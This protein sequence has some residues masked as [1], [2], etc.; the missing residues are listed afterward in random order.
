MGMRMPKIELNVHAVFPCFQRQTPPDLREGGCTRWLLA[1]RIHFGD[2]NG[3][4]TRLCR[5]PPRRNRVNLG[6]EVNCHCNFEAAPSMTPLP[7]FNRGINVAVPNRR[8]ESIQVH[9]VPRNQPLDT[10]FRILGTNALCCAHLRLG[11]AAFSSQ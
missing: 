1:D 2:G 6:G 9:G 8:L 3:A 7:R 11:I 10:S 4:G 5:T